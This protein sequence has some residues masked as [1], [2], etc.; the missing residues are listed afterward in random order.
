MKAKVPTSELVVVKPYD[1]KWVDW[2]KREAAQLSEVLQKE[3]LAIH[4]IGS[5]AVPGLCAKPIVDLMP[6]IRDLKVVD[7]LDADFLDAGFIGMGEYGIKGRRYFMRLRQDTGE[8]RTHVH[9]FRKAT[10]RLRGISLF[11][12]IFEPIPMP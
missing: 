3:V 9:I 4:H 5:T 11:A 2:F 10:L 6:I 1:V 7:E 8:H 12:I